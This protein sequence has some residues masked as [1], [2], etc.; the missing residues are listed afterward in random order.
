MIDAISSLSISLKNS[1]GNSAFK[2]V[3]LAN[4]EYMSF[5]KNRGTGVDAGLKVMYTT[6]IDVRTE[7]VD[8]IITPTTSIAVIK[9]NDDTISLFDNASQKIGVTTWLAGL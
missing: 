1:Y 3:I 2:P 8:K 9:E 7:T 5:R 4:P 6:S